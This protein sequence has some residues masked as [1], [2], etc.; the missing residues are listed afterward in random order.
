MHPAGLAHFEAARGDGRLDAAYAGSA[1]IEVPDD[2][3]AALAASRKATE[4]FATL[5][6]QNRYSILYRLTQI[7]RP[8][9][10]TKRIRTYIEM[11]ERGETLHPQRRR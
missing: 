6:S 3:A 10:R 9:T 7:K 5:T 8:D 11:L 4:M 2:L 1:E